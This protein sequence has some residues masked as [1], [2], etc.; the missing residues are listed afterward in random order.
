MNEG[1][2][3]RRY[4]KALFKT[5]TERGLSQR[6]YSLMQTLAAAFDSNSGIAAVVNNPYVDLADKTRIIST[7]AGATDSDTLF[8]DFLK[9]LAQNHRIGMTGDIAHAFVAEYRHDNNIS[10]VLLTSAAPLPSEVVDRIKKLIDNHLPEGAK[11]EFDTAV[12]PDLLGG[13]IVTIDNQRL[14][15]SVR[16]SLRD[17]RLQLLKK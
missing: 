2:I 7:A 17:L 6:L 16:N 1:L 14:D 11:M 4:A 12:D 9:L 13:F 8:A 5:A 10:R 3:P 15:A